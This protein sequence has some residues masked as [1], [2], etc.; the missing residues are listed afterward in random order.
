VYDN[1]EAERTG[2]PNLPTDGLRRHS[3]V[4]SVVGAAAEQQA[5]VE[6]TMAG[7][8]AR[9]TEAQV[10][11]FS[12]KLKAYGDT[13]PEDEQRLLNSMFIAVLGK[14]DGKEEDVHGFWYAYPYA[15][16]YG[17]PWGYS[18]SYYYPRYW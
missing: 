17:S 14:Q 12:K 2:G 16:W 3:R 1:D 4:T 18:Y 7:T 11:A 13:L 8:S 5:Q 10:E 15:G 9:P 6:E